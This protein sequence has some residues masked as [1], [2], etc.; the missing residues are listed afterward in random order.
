MI[1][2]EQRTIFKYFSYKHLLVFFAFK[3]L[4]YA[5]AKLKKVNLLKPVMVRFIN[6]TLSINLINWTDIVSINE[7]EL[8]DL[9]EKQ[10]YVSGQGTLYWTWVTRPGA[11]HRHWGPYH[12][13]RGLGPRPTRFI[14]VKKGSGV[15]G[16]YSRYTAAERIEGFHVTSRVTNI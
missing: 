10:D 6:G 14:Y 1:D 4:L 12:D 9:S 3:L 16:F 13:T 8:M 11:K 5:F 7:M 2:R 15:F